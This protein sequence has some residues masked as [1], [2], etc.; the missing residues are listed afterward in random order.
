MESYEE[1][2][3]VQPA[4]APGRLLDLDAV[5]VEGG[6]LVVSITWQE[7]ILGVGHGG[8]EENRFI[9]KTCGKLEDLLI[10]VAEGGL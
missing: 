2:V 6:P 9:K 1:L 4:K 7:G 8:E 5:S 3:F 10:E